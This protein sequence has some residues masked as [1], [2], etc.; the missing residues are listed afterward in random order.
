[1]PYTQADLDAVKQAALDLATNKREAAVRFSD[2]SAVTYSPATMPDLQ[3]V[4]EMC[5][6]DVDSALAAASP[7]GRAPFRSI[8]IRPRSGYW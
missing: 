7:N 1:M 2:G 6:R 4:L 5:Q 8:R 3:L